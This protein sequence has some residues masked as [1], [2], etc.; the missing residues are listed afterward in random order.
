MLDMHKLHK[1]QRFQKACAARRYG[2]I[3]IGAPRF[4]CKQ[5]SPERAGVSCQFGFLMPP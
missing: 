1:A 3:V 5:R 2:I 4:D